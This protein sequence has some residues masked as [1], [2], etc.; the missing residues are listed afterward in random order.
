VARVRRGASVRN[1]DVPMAQGEIHSA[2]MRGNLPD[3]QLTRL[4]PRDYIRPTTARRPPSARWRACE[5]P[6]W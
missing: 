6:H 5:A 2:A 1:A 3:R 4:W